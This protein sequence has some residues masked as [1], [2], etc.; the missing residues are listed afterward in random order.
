[1]T[2]PATPV[3]ALRGIAARNPRKQAF[4]FT[5]DGLETG[6]LD[7]SQLLNASLAQASRISAVAAPGE[8]AVL[9]ADASPEFVTAFLGCLLAGVVAVPVPPVGPGDDNGS[10]ARLEGVVADC[11]PRLLVAGRQH[12]DRLDRI[13]ARGRVPR[14]KALAVTVDA[15]A[16]TDPTGSQVALP[17]P[18]A[19]ARAVLQYTSGSTSSPRGVVLTHRNLA[20]NL[21]MLAR[22]LRCGPES[23]IVSWLPPF[24]DMG[25][26]TGVLLAPYT[27]AGAVLMPQYDFI[28]APHRW[29]RTIHAHRGTISGAP[30]F[31][32][33]HLLTH[34]G[35]ERLAGTDLSSW[36]TAFC[37]AEP[38]RPATMRSVA[39]GLA[40]Y[41]FRP[42]A[43]MP[44][45]G[46]AEATLI[47]SGGPNGTGARSLTVR[48][49]DLAAGVLASA[50]GGSGSVTEVASC[51]RPTQGTIIRVLTPGGLEEL[52]PGRVGEICVLGPSVA[53]GYW[54]APASDATFTHTPDGTL[55]R[56]GDL[57]ALV[58]GEL[59]VTGR[60]KDL[61][62]VAGHNIHPQD[63]EHCVTRASALVR[64]R[65]CAV[66]D[67]R[68]DGALPRIVAVAEVA[69]GATNDDLDSLGE[70][71]FSAV[72]KENEVRLDRVVLVPPGTVP[73]TSSGK[74][75]RRACRQALRDRSLTVLRNWSPD[76]LPVTAPDHTRWHDDREAV[77]ADL[78]LQV[79]GTKPATADEEL[80]RLGG[81]SL[82][83]LGL[84]NKVNQVLGCAIDVTTAFETP[85]VAGLALAA[86]ASTRD[87][88]EPGLRRP[89][90][91]RDDDE[92]QLLDDIALDPAVAP[93]KAPFLTS[94]ARPGEVLLTGVTGFVGAHLLNELLHRTGSRVHCVVRARD[95]A[96]AQARVDAAI[97]E[98]GLAPID[99]G[100]VHAYAGDLAQHRFSLPEDLYTRLAS[101]VD[102][103][104]NNA[105]SVSA[106]QSYGTIRG[107][108]V[109]GTHHVLR[110]A[111]RTRLKRVH[112]ISTLAVLLADDPVARQGLEARIS[113]RPEVRLRSSG[114]WLSKWAAEQ[115]VNTAAERGLPVTI[116][117][118]ARVSGHSSTGAWAR[119]DFWNRILEG[120]LRIG[121]L[122]DTKWA[123][124]FTPVDH[125]AAAVVELMLQPRSTGKVFHIADTPVVDITD[126]ARWLSETGHPVGTLPWEQWVEEVSSDPD[127]PMALLIPHLRQGVS[128]RASDVLPS[129]EQN[130]DC[131]Q[132]RRALDGTGITFPAPGPALFGRYADA[133]GLP[134]DHPET[135]VGSAP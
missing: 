59:H 82:A 115:L 99:A 27:G 15:G 11:A 113:G 73:K 1:M 13:A 30:N 80:P 119:G 67:D 24:H 53:D 130:V 104:V 110:F 91:L 131:R 36:S 116:H 124:R 57:G 93:P 40:R 88:S 71:L 75:R 129:Q 112:H 4:A 48:R 97:A 43:L 56:T 38:V 85:T 114:Y 135:A 8:R 126:I 64:P 96:S 34:A 6:H 10:A 61:I 94:A 81:G 102:V 60:I 76:A 123:D 125:V 46:L 121:A 86:A 77:I 55:L 39:T 26:L 37:G 41:G 68:A 105:A 16:T 108:N 132:F 33:E 118:L 45:Y 14:P 127:N 22:T 63:V 90:S 2:L 35:D 31:G 87:A 72:A 51:G 133:L 120:G 58:D 117:R 17:Q 79:I 122:P 65:G 9:L 107:A 103:V 42:S 109:T 28:R 95:D 74:V 106:A 78:C 70:R 18:D 134:V 32:Y 5:R 62:V 100:R 98:Y 25:L 54:K 12:A 7:Y 69:V 49:K 50:K 23:V 29:L 111:A 44:A 101:S 92:G 66:F 84:I 128:G 21:D 20:A 83:M 19:A 3:E 47:V 52:P 89:P